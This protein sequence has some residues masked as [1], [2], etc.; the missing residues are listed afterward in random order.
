MDWPDIPH[1]TRVR[2]SYCSSR[3]GEE[4]LEVDCNHALSQMPTSGVSVYYRP[5]ARARPEDVDTPKDYHDV[6]DSKSF[7]SLSQ[8]IACPVHK[9]SYAASTQ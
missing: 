3:L 7:L 1:Y 9:R 5:R 6:S 2:N 4:M 8:A